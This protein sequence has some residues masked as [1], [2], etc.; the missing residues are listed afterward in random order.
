[1]TPIYASNRADVSGWYA[2]D[3]PLGGR[4]AFWDGGVGKREQQATGFWCPY[5]G[6][7]VDV[8]DRVARNMPPVG[9]DCVIV[10]DEVLV[11][12]FPKVVHMH[13]V[14]DGEPEME[15]VKYLYD[16]PSKVGNFI[17]E[18]TIGEELI[19]G[20]VCRMVSVE[21]LPDD[22]YAAL[23]YFREKYPYGV[24]R[25]PMSVWTPLRTVHYAAN[26]PPETVYEGRVREIYHTDDIETIDYVN[27]WAT[28]E[29]ELKVV[30]L[31]KGDNE[32]DCPFWKIKTPITLYCVEDVVIGYE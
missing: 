24:A 7:I 28:I 27:V 13:G 4:R 3:V 15:A 1:M 16:D 22:K 17:D 26:M 12:G 11:T 31:Y 18:L 5:H 6:N 21:K 2:F 25:H 30:P 9:L 8:P 10:G 23:D 32:T 20:S 19:D 14:I 29:K